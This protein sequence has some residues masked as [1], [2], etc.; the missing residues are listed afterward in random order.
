MGAPARNPE[1]TIELDPPREPI[2]GCV[3][4][5]DGRR[6]PFSGWLELMDILDHAR[7]HSQDDRKDRMTTQLTITE[8]LDSKFIGELIG[9]D[10]PGYNA[11][12]KLY[13]GMFDK[14][15]ALI[16]RCTC[17]EDVQAA[18][19]HARPHELV[20]A[21]RGGGH[22]TQGSPAAMGES[23]S[24]PPAEKRRDR[25]RGAH[26]PLRRRAHVGGA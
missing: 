8:G 15:P 5:T 18:L 16:A 21:V 2:S 20:V 24:T 7:Y 1:L 9:P 23:W 3:T 25:R 11:A 17:P 4:D 6:R 12:R 22:S 13:N 14:R 10:H 26:G 19:D